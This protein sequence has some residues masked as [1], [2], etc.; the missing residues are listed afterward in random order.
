MKMIL[1]QHGVIPIKMRKNCKTI[2]TA[3]YE[4]KFEKIE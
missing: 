4:Q 2:G 3:K 1:F